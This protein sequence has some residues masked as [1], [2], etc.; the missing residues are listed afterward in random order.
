MKFIL[1]LFA[2]GAIIY[3]SLVTALLFNQGHLAIPS[4]AEC[5]ATTVASQTS[6]SCRLVSR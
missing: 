5:L 1:I 2:S 6:V 4:A 3:A